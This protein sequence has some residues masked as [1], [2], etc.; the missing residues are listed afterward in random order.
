MT[1][2][3]TPT[4][5][6]DKN[7]VPTTRNK[8][9]VKTVIKRDIPAMKTAMVQEDESAAAVPIEKYERQVSFA[10]NA[11]FEAA[12]TSPSMREKLNH[13]GHEMLSAMGS[14]RIIIK[15]QREEIALAQESRI[16]DM[17][18]NIK[19]YA[20]Y[21]LKTRMEE[22]VGEDGKT[23]LR[24]PDALLFGDVDVEAVDIE[25]VKKIAAEWQQLAVAI[26]MA[27]ERR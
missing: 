14:L 21:A 8:K 16:I 11:I 6:V 5:I 12:R 17:S 22:F 7:G 2:S 24:L 4:P 15:R 26:E 27:R 10:A 25:H 18:K 9:A 23:Y 13:V 3:T 1:N 19:S 20:P